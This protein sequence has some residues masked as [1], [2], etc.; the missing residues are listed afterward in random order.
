MRTVPFYN[1]FLPNRLQI[2][3]FGGILWANG[4]MRMELFENETLNISRIVTAKKYGDESAKAGSDGWIRYGSAPLVYELIFFLS[5]EA[6]CRFDGTELR[7][8]PGTVRYLPKGRIR[9]EY[10]VRPIVPGNCIDIYFDTADP[11]P[12]RAAAFPG[13]EHLRE[14]FTRLYTVWT[15]NRSGYYAE[16][17][18]LFYKIIGSFRAARL[19]YTDPEQREAVYSAYEYLRTH[20]LERDFDYNAMCACSGLSYSAFSERFK[21]VYHMPPVRMVTR[22]RIAHACELLA[23]GRFTVSETAEAC[24]FENVFYFSNVFKKATGI[25][26]REYRP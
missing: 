21:K 25:P 17:M 16:S 19:A 7:D 18:S 1:L 10:L 24:G 5:S 6:V 22:M 12:G 23:T 4:G 26:P 20:C 2:T 9:G 15:R 14:D 11:M 8:A 13:M 3:R